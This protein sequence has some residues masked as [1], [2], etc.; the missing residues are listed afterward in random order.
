MGSDRTAEFARKFRELNSI[1]QKY[2]LAIQQA[3]V[4]AQASTME[5]ENTK[6]I[7]DV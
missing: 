5:K 2:I 1:N 3:L 6:T 7:A 4:F